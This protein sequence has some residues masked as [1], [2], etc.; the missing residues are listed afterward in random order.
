MG[1]SAEI[2]RWWGNGSRRINDETD[3]S[4]SH[5][6]VVLRPPE[7]ADYNHHSTDQRDA[8]HPDVW[9]DRDLDCAGAARYRA[10]DCRFYRWWRAGWS[11]QA[12]LQRN[13]ASNHAHLARRTTF[14]GGG[15]WRERRLLG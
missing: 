14:A 15:L 6:A 4:C 7:G 8:G 10:G 2:S 9:A 13:R 1:G 5:D 11:G 3:R 12:E